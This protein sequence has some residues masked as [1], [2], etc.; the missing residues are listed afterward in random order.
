MVKQP[1]E[2]FEERTA[3]IADAVALGEPDRVPFARFATFFPARYSGTSFHDAM[4]DNAKLSEAVT[5]FMRISSPTP[6]PILFAFWAGRQPWRYWTTGN[7][8]GLGM[9]ESRTSPTSSLKANT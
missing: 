1:D 4:H 2:L 7:W 9:G 6:S 3:R 5:R 8:F